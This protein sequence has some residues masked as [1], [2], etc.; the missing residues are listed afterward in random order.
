MKNK[1]KYSTTGLELSSSV[2]SVYVYLAY[3]VCFTF[4]VYPRGV[5]LNVYRIFA[6]KNLFV[7]GIKD[8]CEGKDWYNSISD[9]KDM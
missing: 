4:N 3:F 5:T 6:N 8:A 9:F 7:F 2:I 1:Q